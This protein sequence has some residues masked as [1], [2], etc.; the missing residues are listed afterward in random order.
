MGDPLLWL[1]TVIICSLL[2]GSQISIEDPK[3]KQSANNNNNNKPPQNNSSSQKRPAQQTNN[4]RSNNKP[5]TKCPH[6]GEDINE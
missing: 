3:H 4:N 6:C 5:I 1:G 2:I